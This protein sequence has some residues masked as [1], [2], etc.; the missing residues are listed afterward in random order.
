MLLPRVVFWVC[1]FTQL[2]ATEDVRVIP[3]SVQGSGLLGCVDDECGSQSLMRISLEALGLERTCNL[4]GTWV[5]VQHPPLNLFLLRKNPS[6]PS[7]AAGIV[8]ARDA[9]TLL[10]FKDAVLVGRTAFSVRQFV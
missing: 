4:L 9:G 3:L 5:S 6:R 1:F 8:S 7:C 10:C 2:Y